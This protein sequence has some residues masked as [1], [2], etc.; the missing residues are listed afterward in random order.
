MATAAILTDTDDTPAS[1]NTPCYLL[2]T[3]QCPDT[4]AFCCLWAARRFIVPEDAECRIVFIESSTRLDPEDEIG[5]EVIYMD[6][7]GGPCD[8]HGKQ[9]KRESSFGLLIEHYGLAKDEAL[10]WCLK[11]ILEM[12]RA[13]DN[14]ERVHPMSVH[15]I[16]KGLRNFIREGD[17]TDWS[18]VCD[19]AFM[20]LDIL[21]EQQRGRLKSFMKYEKVGRPRRLR[22]GIVLSDLAREPGLREA[23]WNTGVDVVIWTPYRGRRLEVGIAVGRG[24][25][26]VVLDAVVRNLR[27]LEARKRGINTDGQDLATI[28]TLDSLPTWFYHDS[29]KLILAGS[30]SHRLQ[31]DE[32]TQLTR[33]D[34]RNAVV[35]GLESLKR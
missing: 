19:A 13:T 24:S 26:A 21:Y 27:L 34:I 16:F 32:F 25:R 20:M 11:P 9:L 3:H 35:A 15:N 12:T 4:D 14:A 6:V 18:G 31:G 22:N 10:E 7:G 2:V 8:Q 17:E 29:R 30:R 1:E 23:A 5:H 33:N 28:G